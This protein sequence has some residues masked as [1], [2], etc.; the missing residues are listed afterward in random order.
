MSRHLAILLLAALPLAAETPRRALMPLDTRPAVYTQTTPDVATDGRDFIAVWADERAKDRPNFT[1]GYAVY[2]S[3]LTEDGQAVDPFGIELTSMGYEP[4]IEWNGRTWLVAF[5]DGREAYAMRISAQARPLEAP[6]QIANRLVEDLATDGSTFCALT[7]NYPDSAIVLLDENANVLRRVPVEGR[8]GSVVSV[9][10][11]YV[12]FTVSGTSLLATTLSRDGSLT[13]KSIATIGEGSLINSYSNGSRVLVTWTNTAMTG[14][15]VLDD[16][17]TAVALPLQFGKPLEGM[18]AFGAPSIAWDGGSFL[19]AWPESSAGLTAVRVAANGRMT[20]AGPFEV[21]AKSEFRAATN[22]FRTIL[23]SSEEVSEAPD[24][25]SRVLTLDGAV[26]DPRV[27]AFSGTPQSEPQAAALGNTVLAVVREGESYGGITAALFAPDKPGQ[28]RIVV[29]PQQWNVTE[30]GPSVAAGA[31]AFLVAWREVTDYRTR[32]LAKRV[33]PSGTVLDPEPLVVA[34]E[35][36]AVEHF[37]ETAVAWNGESFLVVWHSPGDQIVARVVGRNG[38][39]GA[40]SIVSTANGNLFRRTPA[41]LWTGT[42]YFVAWSETEPLNGPVSSENPQRT[43]Y[44]SAHLSADANVLG[45]PETLF[46][47]TG[48]C[49]GLALAANR[50]NILLVTTTGSYLSGADWPVHTLFLDADGNAVSS[51]PKRIDT[52]TPT[53]RR[54]HPAAAWNGTSFLVF[55]NERPWLEDWSVIEGRTVATNGIVQSLGLDRAPSFFPAAATFAG[56]AVLVETAALEEQAHV[57][58]L[59][60]RTF[61]PVRSKTRA[62]R[63]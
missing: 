22:G 18:Y 59:Y 47:A 33:L 53:F 16:R 32:I 27:I 23:V 48:Y 9:A 15:V 40:T 7:E 46:I 60:T 43:A 42:S 26:S 34:D 5:N 2:A 14:I 6:K 21:A 31:D 49:Q 30:D 28:S 35:G 24:A 3:R 1:R 19:V 57:A 17:S 20:G 25:V 44:R 13:Q 39:L 61:A 55:W 52:A 45:E 54:M 41:A 29:V 12:V 58:R 37:G 10:R 50:Q 36:R 63:P 38:V 56:G 4:Q 8:G 62:A 11:N 51:A